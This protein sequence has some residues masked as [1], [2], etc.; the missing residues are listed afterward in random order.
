M[1]KVRQDPKGENEQAQQGD[2]WEKQAKYFQ[3]EKDKLFEESRKKDKLITDF[4]NVL[5]KPGVV[6]AIKGA[7]NPNAE[8]KQA[9]VEMSEDD[10]DPWSAWNDP[11]SKSYQFR[12]GKER[13]H[14]DKVMNEKVD[15]RMKTMVEPLMKNMHVNDMRGYLTERGYDKETQDK[16]FDFY[17]KQTNDFSRDEVVDMFE[18]YSKIGRQPESENL[19]AVRAGKNNFTQAGVLEGQSPV[20]LEEAD[21]V[22]DRIL[23]SGSAGGSSII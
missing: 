21:T 2:D 18:G 5:A 14:I 23:G 9:E 3:S 1:T 4:K 20:D 15:S 12:V 8:S 16:F 11:S 19:N 10:F 17:S 6:D 7:L 13:Q 22:F